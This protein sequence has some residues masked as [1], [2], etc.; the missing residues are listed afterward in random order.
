MAEINWLAA[1]A[2]GILGFLP[3]ALWYSKLMFLKAW[4]AETG[5]E[6]HV[7]NMPESVRM[8]SGLALSVA[9]AIAFAFFLGP[10][11]PLQSALMWGLVVGAAFITTALG[12]QYLF[13]GKS[14]RL[15]L[16][17]GG[18]HIVQFVTF[19]FVLGLWH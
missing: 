13:E 7:D 1:V 16:I 19:G 8:A 18:Y 5:I 17:N 12:I 10:L 9:A 15:T 2:A 3:G 6:G 14:L 4:Q 11:P